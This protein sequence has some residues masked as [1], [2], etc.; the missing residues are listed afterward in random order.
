MA[1]D[2]LAA[3][4]TAQASADEARARE[5]L[6]GLCA[7][8]LPA[9]PEELDELSFDLFGPLM[10][11]A[12]EPAAERLLLAVAEVASAREVVCLVMEAF[13]VHR[14]PTAQLLLVRALAVS[15]PRIARKREAFVETCLGSLYARFLREWPADE[16]DEAVEGG[17]SSRS[18]AAQLFGVLLQ[19]VGPLAAE[20]AEAV[21]SDGAAARAR[22]LVLGFLWRALEVAVAV[23]TPLDVAAVLDEL[24]RAK[25]TSGELVA[26]SE[27]GAA[28]AASGEGG[29]A[30][31]D[32]HVGEQA[33]EEGSGESATVRALLSPG[34]VGPALQVHAEC[35]GERA[36]RG[37]PVGVTPPVAGL[38]ARGEAGAGAA[39]AAEVD[40]SSRLDAVV[41]TLPAGARLR[42]VA[43]LA[44]ALLAQPSLATR[45][46]AL[47]SWL[48]GPA[49]AHTAAVAATCP[50]VATDT[51]TPATAQRGQLPPTAQPAFAAAARRL[52][53]HMSTCA[54][55][56]ERAAAYATLRRLLWL[57][58]AEARL[59]LLLA[60]IRECGYPAA[61][62]LL[63]HRLKE[64]HIVERDAAAAATRAAVGAEPASSPSSPQ[65][66]FT[67]A[68]LLPAATPLLVP[69]REYEGVDVLMG[70]LNLCRFLVADREAQL[71]SS[72]VERLRRDTLAPLDQQL[73]RSMDGLWAAMQQRQRDSPESA[74]LTE[75]Q[76]RFTHLHVAAE[77]A[78]RVVDLCAPPGPA[79]PTGSGGSS[80]ITESETG[81]A[82]GRDGDMAGTGG[83]DTPTTSCPA[84]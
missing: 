21:G 44:A 70:A 73:R 55:A 71:S 4:D 75:M 84:P 33:E 58:P 67:A 30:R 74:E 34:P 36:A 65:R 3:L 47:L 27:E 9:D 40:S 20:A 59:E 42:L 57:P 66:V 19:V 63:L 31:K 32:G 68:A 39:V 2:L 28:A 12:A 56:Q 81:R 50:A 64:E 60:L 43:L 83:H 51:R 8:L 24:R 41:L 76:L 61:V 79:A 35:C 7:K 38:E 22:Q 69:P 18:C 72:A 29:G 23:G 17:S 52:V 25:P 14:T 26:A 78:Q 15:L 45:G 62:A 37:R 16:W 13:G 6:D 77:V 11:A 49:A 48:V 80:S 54:D 10:Q 5:A 53:A 82:M 46:H 1:L